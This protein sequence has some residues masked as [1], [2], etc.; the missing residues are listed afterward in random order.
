MTDDVLA[1]LK[2][3]L[4]DRYAIE[5]ELGSGGMATV[6]LAEDLKHRRKVAVKVLRPN[7]AAALGPQRFL[8]EI[9]IAAQL[10]HPNIL[11]LYD[12]GEADGFLFYVMPH[13]EGASLRD[14]LARE[15]EL[16]IADAV[17]IMRDVVDALTEAH[18][19]GV[20]HRDIKPENILLRGRHALVTDFG[21]AKAVSE[22]TG[23]EQLTT[24]GVALGT[25][26][27]MAPEQASADPHLD[28]RVDI[29]AVG[30]V[31][32]ELLTGRPVF[33]GTTPQMVL[34]AHMTERPQPVSKQR[35]TVPAAL[36]A[37]V[38]RCL[39][40]KPADRWQSAAELLPQLELLATPSGGI[41]PTDT[42]PTV[43]VP[44]RR[45]V[46]LAALASAA[47]LAAVVT[48]V[49]LLLRP[50]GA[51]DVM[52]GSVVR[53]VTSHVGWEFSPSWSPDGSMI[54]YAHIVAGDADIAT[55]SIGGGEPHILTG[56][57]PAD[58]ILPSWSPD[59]SK[60]AY[61][62]D[63]GTGTDVY[64]IPPTGGA[65]HKVAE[66]HIPFLE[67]MDA[68]AGVLGRNA[69]SPDGQ[70]LL[71]ARLHDTGDV[72]VW[73]V[74]LATG[75]QT[76]LTFPPPGISDRRASWS[77]DGE[78]IAF[79]RGGRG[80]SSIWLL[81][82][83]G[84]E[85]SRLIE[86]A[87]A[88]AWYPDDERIAF[89]SGR[90]GARNVWQIE[91]HSGEQRQLTTGGRGN[92]QTPVVAR[93][94]AI[95][96]VEF[97]HQIDIYWL[98]LDTLEP[99]HERLT[100]FTGE[101]FAPRIS[102]D[103]NRVVYYRGPP[104]DL[105]LLDRTTG[106]HRGLTDDPAS[107]RMADWS[108]DGAE[109]VFMSNR[110]GAVRLWVL[111]VETGVARRLTD[112]ALPWAMHAGDTQNGPRW[113]PDGSVIGY[114]APHEAGTAI[115]LVAPDGSN[116][117]PSSIGDAFSFGWYRDSQRVIYTR[118]AR[119]GSGLVEL[120]AAHLGRGEDVLL[121]MGALSE[122]SV[123]PD[124]TAL[125]YIESVSH[126]TMDL[127]LLN[128]EPPTTSDQL[129]RAVGEPRQITFGNG[130]WHV[131]AGGWAPDGSGIVYSRDTDGGDIYVIEPRR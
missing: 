116:R 118:R 18:E 91:L 78:R 47:A 102:P 64:W 85:P 90:G 76:Q 121:R 23:R 49:L 30:C 51:P 28:Q 35:D 86:D 106:Q 13:I 61:V 104:Y 6:Y 120:R 94:G 29:Y 22:A 32:Y 24:A 114:L 108:P 71:F 88:P 21:V 8:Q 4:A 38:L 74:N 60:I 93:N 109:M 46:A 40:K 1:R 48:A 117:R 124:G 53:R 33:M 67:R 26:A 36:E 105:W 75:E 79:E 42:R 63:R 52:A 65:E 103:G 83:E 87:R 66:T 9:E 17:R 96:Y 14:K 115:W 130:V 119:D 111:E 122:L 7:L 123:S 10:Q 16:P 100:T 59:G 37:V 127:Q 131:H 56:E 12:S 34:A 54:A 73:K 5:S 92:D 41:T 68:W 101:N 89:T 72:A 39:E 80:S 57:S 99:V 55:L 2:Q 50:G 98:R 84:G 129:P 77:F 113:S 107:D 97:D 62:S 27:Y 126:F 128:L 58:E 125:T 110:D 3:A 82:V 112:H 70:E 43:A 31:A 20:V 69:W 11:P 19:H 45:T 44:R 15:G 81:P 95:A 25:P